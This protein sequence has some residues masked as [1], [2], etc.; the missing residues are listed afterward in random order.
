MSMVPPHLCC[1][2]FQ[3]EPCH[4]SASGEFIGVFYIAAASEGNTLIVSGFLLL[5]VLPK[6]LFLCSQ[7]SFALP[8]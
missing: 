2:G 3:R 8:L 4:F 1:P 7:P 6:S 5:L